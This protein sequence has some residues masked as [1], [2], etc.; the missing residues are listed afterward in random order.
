MAGV[1]VLGTGAHGKAELCITKEH[2]QQDG[3]HHHHG[4]RSNFMGLQ[5][6]ALQKCEFLEGARVSLGVVPPNQANGAVDDQ[7]HTDER[8]DRC[9]AA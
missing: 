2:L 6:A 8:R 4:Q 1:G 3:D 9:C 7:E 5:K